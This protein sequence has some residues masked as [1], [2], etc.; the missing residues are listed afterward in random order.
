MHSY[1]HVC[2]I[3][4]A[5]EWCTGGLKFEYFN[6]DICVEKLEPELYAREGG[7]FSPQPPPP[8]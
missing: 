3:Q 2:V 1:L 8:Y 4:V 7:V 6:V 5:D